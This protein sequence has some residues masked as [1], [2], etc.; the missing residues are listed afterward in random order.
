MNRCLLLG[1]SWLRFTV[2]VC[3]FA[4]WLP[5]SSDAGMYRVVVGEH[6]LY[7]YGGTEQ[8]L[9]VERITVH[10]GWTGDLGKG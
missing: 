3:G 5:T 6:N 10:P 7:V 1:S 4:P 2:R 8:F 9:E